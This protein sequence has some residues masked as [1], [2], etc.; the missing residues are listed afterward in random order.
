MSAALLLK[1][2]QAHKPCKRNMDCLQSSCL[3]L[4]RS[5]C[6]LELEASW[7][8]EGLFSVPRK[9]GCVVL[10]KAQAGAAFC[11]ITHHS[12]TA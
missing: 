2:L 6:S 11:T 4:L 10:T 3:R 8:H 7:V 5:M 12:E 9:L 1:A